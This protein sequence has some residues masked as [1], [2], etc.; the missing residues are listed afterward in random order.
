MLKA[1]GE[2]DLTVEVRRGEVLNIM[3]VERNVEPDDG[4]LPYEDMKKLL[5]SQPT[6]V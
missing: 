4:N 1:M 6:K 3:K 5:H 2:L